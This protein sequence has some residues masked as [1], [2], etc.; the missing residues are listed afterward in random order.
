M[1]VKKKHS[2]FKANE[3]KNPMTRNIS[4]FNSEP[5]LGVKYCRFL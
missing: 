1:E 2:E 4:L 5:V 3:V